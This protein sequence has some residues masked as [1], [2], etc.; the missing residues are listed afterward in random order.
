LFPTTLLSGAERIVMQATLY[1]VGL[2]VTVWFYY[3][4]ASQCCIILRQDIG[5][6]GN[7]LEECKSVPAGVGCA[8]LMSQTS[9]KPEGWMCHAFP[10]QDNGYHFLTVIAIQI[11]IMFPVKMTLTRMF[12]AGGGTILEPHWQQAI[13][14]AGM[15]MMEVWVAWAEVLFQLLTD[16][17]GAMQRPEIGAILKASKDAITRS[18][19]VALMTNFMILMGG[20]SY[21][22]D[23]LGIYR[24]R[25]A[26]QVRFEAVHV[27]REKIRTA[28]GPVA[29]DGAVALLVAG[30]KARISLEQALN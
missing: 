12:T 24:A 6:S 30:L 26:R 22:L 16:P 17:A 8:V 5:C 1:L 23:R 15:N 10:D 3:N 2:L 21:A 7:V 25:K 9:L 20:V 28:A 18:L 19:N 11:S 29:V 14:A 27:I 4:K 13:V